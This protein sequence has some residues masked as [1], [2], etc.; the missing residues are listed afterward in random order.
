MAWLRRERDR[1]ESPDLGIGPYYVAPDSAR[2][3]PSTLWEG[4]DRRDLKEVVKESNDRLRSSLTG[5]E[6]GAPAT[7]TEATFYVSPQQRQALNQYAGK[8]LSSV[9][10]DFDDVR[11]R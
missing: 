7:T 1:P 4:L 5:G 10:E 3:L 11:K 6:G 8:A 2:P 9:L